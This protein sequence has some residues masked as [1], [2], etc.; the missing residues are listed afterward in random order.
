MY[1]WICMI[2]TGSNSGMRSGT[3]Q[4]YGRLS[5]VHSIPSRSCLLQIKYAFS[6]GDCLPFRRLLHCFQ[7]GS[8]T[9]FSVC[10]AYNKLR[11][12][13]IWNATNH[14][15]SKIRWQW[16]TWIKYSIIFYLENQKT[17]LNTAN[18]CKPDCASMVA[19][20]Y[21][22]C[23]LWLAP[24]ELEWERTTLISLVR[25]RCLSELDRTME[26]EWSVCQLPITTLRWTWERVLEHLLESQ[27]AS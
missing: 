2:G 6:V 17:A 25:K 20:H 14:L 26:T 1:Y 4:R 18:W 5:W 19:N 10:N 3:N 16:S 11:A 13:I 22:V 7:S 12:L 9:A 24:N 23:T 21:W 8:E 15:C 27:D